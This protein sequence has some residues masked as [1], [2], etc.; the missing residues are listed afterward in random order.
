MQRK[1]ERWL[2]SDDSRDYGWG[3]AAAFERMRDS[4]YAALKDTVYLDH[5]AS[6]PV[7][8][9][10]LGNFTSSLQSTLLSNPHS[11]STSGVATSLTIDRTRTRVLTDLFG[12]SPERVGEWDVV[13]THGGATQGIKMVGEA[14]NWRGESDL[15][16]RN[17]LEY[18]VE[19][20]TS[21]VG[22][23]GIA[24]ARSSPVLSHRTPS[25]L[26]RSARSS[27][28]IPVDPSSDTPTLYTYPAQCNATG[29]RLGLGFCAQIKRANP[30]AKVLVDAAAYSSTSVLDLGAC[31]EGEEPDFVV[32]S[33]YKIFG[34]PTSLGLLVVRRSSAHLLTHSPYF[35]GGTVSSL[36]LSSPFS[37]SSRYTSPSPSLPTFPP[38]LPP[39]P[40]L[41]SSSSIHEILEAGT[42][43]FLEI[44]ALSHS[45]DWLASITNGQGLGAVGK[46]VA[47]LR[48]VLVSE[49]EGLRHAGGGKVFVEHRAF[50][51]DGVGEQDGE[52][53]AV[54]LEQPGPIVG[55]S[56]LLPPSSA[57]TAAGADVTDY[58]T[59]VVGHVHLS[60]LALLN[61]IALR[62]GGLCNTGV[63]TRVW[64]L[65]DA[66]LA[67]LE[68]KGRKCWD[69]E[70]FAPFEP[71]K[72]LGMARV[73]LGLAST[74]DDVLKF[75][76]FVRK[77]FVANE[78]VVALEKPLEKE[79]DGKKVRRAALKELMIYP[80]KSCAAQSFPPSTPWPLT[81]S[82]LLY[83]RELMLVSTSTGRAL[84]QKRYSRM[85]LIRPVVDREKGLLVVEAPGMEPLVL[86]LPEL[87]DDA[88][89]CGLDTPPLSED[90]HSL[91][92]GSSTDSRTRPL[93]NPRSTT[94]C[95]SAVSSVRVSSM[96]DTWFTRFLNSQSSSSSTTA[97]PGPVELRRLPPGSSRHAHFDSSG[98]PLPI[99][100]SNESPFL[101]VTSESL[102]AVNDWI[103]RDSGMKQEKE[104]KAAA[105]R[106][107]I[108]VEG[109]DADLPPFWE[110]KVDELRVGGE[111]FATLGRCRR[112]LMVAV[113]QTTGQRTA[114]PLQT[115]SH[116]RKF[117]SSG[118][119]EFG[120]HCMW[121]EELSKGQAAGTIS[122]GDE[123]V[124]A[125]GGREEL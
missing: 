50:Q 19:S 28:S 109:D 45:L 64:D 89:Y 60:R 122:V 100:L 51:E 32:A 99:R 44:L 31:R 66:D 83:D 63:W 33:M 61:S 43:P 108:V 1:R 53:Q 121:R 67:A 46:H 41:S 92:G 47:W 85:A 84:S 69:E 35:G 114:E 24:L 117:A 73:S 6:P 10:P 79:A 38:T 56:L 14:W 23:R 4:E 113:D 77:F 48:G 21:L 95:G 25:S 72:P 110:D 27:R 75:V 118:R 87:D 68:A 116:Y 54:H 107:N 9:T 52:K 55:F 74:L 57:S 88:S 119:V 76:E 90:G 105:F 20:H 80:I 94:L 17:G 26:L 58:R 106:P 22:L 123:V 29:Y 39:S 98:P 71:Y 30:E 111:V 102:K 103:E 2:A 37:H 40:A 97:G 3:D 8:K 101:L 62:S 11:A 125:F 34:F 91:D 93:D 104:V 86:P 65:S 124:V 115:L 81:P 7:P 15:R 12:V 112:C 18:L 36:S 5:A 82:G 13:F 120:V 49:L 59:H 42:P 96:A 78:Q 16:G 70:E